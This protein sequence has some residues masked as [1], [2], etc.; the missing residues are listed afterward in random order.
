LRAHTFRR[1]TALFFSVKKVIKTWCG[2]VKIALAQHEKHR[3]WE[4]WSVVCVVVGRAG[5]ERVDS[6]IRKKC[7]QRSALG[8]A[9]TRLAT[10]DEL[11]VTF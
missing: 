11:G 5:V 4:R 1:G 2:R 10:R 6:T 9:V 3:P 7:V 8:G